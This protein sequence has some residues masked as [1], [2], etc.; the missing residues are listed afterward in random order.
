MTAVFDALLDSVGSFLLVLSV[1]P[2]LGLCQCF[3]NWLSPVRTEVTSLESVWEL[4][5][6]SHPRVSVVNNTSSRMGIQKPCFLDSSNRDLTCNLHSRFVCASFHPLYSDL[7][8]CLSVSL[9]AREFPTKTLL[10]E[11]LT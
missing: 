10:L 11:N 4:G 8:T 6:G 9:K 2:S 7:F 1:R 3:E 5:H